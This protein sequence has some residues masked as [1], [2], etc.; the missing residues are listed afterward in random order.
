MTDTPLVWLASLWVEYAR[1]CEQ[2]TGEAVENDEPSH[3][4]L[5]YQHA[6]AHWT[7]AA[8][9]FLMWMRED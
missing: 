4:S 2:Q 7:M 9:H 3:A 6:Q 8:V 1:E 5:W